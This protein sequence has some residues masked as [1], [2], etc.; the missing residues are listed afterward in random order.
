VVT[1]NVGR[2]IFIVYS[3]IMVPV[4]AVLINA[5]YE[6]FSSQVR[7]VT[8]RGLSKF[9]IRRPF[10]REEEKPGN[11]A[12]LEKEVEGGSETP[13]VNEEILQEEVMNEMEVIN[14]KVEKVGKKMG[15]DKKVRWE[16]SPSDT[17]PVGSEGQITAEIGIIPD[18][19]IHS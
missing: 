9:R 7:E 2:A 16:L 15:T 3:F 17:N 19:T 1:S 11:A 13:N 18:A 10:G 14:R 4:L 5:I 12:G 6:A 8:I